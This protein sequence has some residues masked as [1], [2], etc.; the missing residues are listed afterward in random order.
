MTNYLTGFA[1]FILDIIL[2]IP[3]KIFE[4]LTDG[5]AVTIDALFNLCSSCNFTT[6]GASLEG[7]PSGILYI[8]GWF[9]FGTGISVISGAYL[10]RF[11]IRRLPVIG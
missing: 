3:K 11:L 6:L 10:I 8:L 5:L 4:W 9:N 1:Q 7:L 2:Y